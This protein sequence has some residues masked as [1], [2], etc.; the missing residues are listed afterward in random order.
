MGRT[1]LQG[2]A[3]RML[4]CIC[5]A[6]QRRRDSKPLGTPCLRTLCPS[7]W[8]VDAN[9]SACRRVSVQWTGKLDPTLIAREA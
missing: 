5:L 7:S 6:P 1:S 4:N 2:Y 9:C 8:T 3:A